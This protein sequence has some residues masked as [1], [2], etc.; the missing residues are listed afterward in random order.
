MLES[1][2]QQ[3]RDLWEH[4]WWW[5]A[6]TAYVRDWVRW[7]AARRRLDHILDIGCGDG[8]MFEILDEFGQVQ[9][10]ESDGRLLS[11]ENP[12]RRRIEN[13][14]FDANYQNRRQFDLILMLDV[15]EHIADDREA[16]AHVHNLLKPEG[17]ALLTVPALPCLWSRHDVANQH[18]RRYTRRSL[19]RL[20]AG[21]GWQ[22]LK[23]E[24]FS[25]WTIAPMLL[26][27]LLV[28]AGA[29][30]DAEPSYVVRIPPLGINRLAEAACRVEQLVG[31]VVPLPLG[32][33][34]LVIAGRV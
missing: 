15:L 25:L 3:Y 18:Y 10:L 31:R 27:R 9:G 21:Q 28:P 22:I 17:L 34:C 7:L 6:R 20:L 30:S 19:G 1:Y 14:P 2:A 23:L 4:H 26:R 13:V 12:A 11:P 33:S 8:L 5:R 16:I 32:S 24:Y 29:P